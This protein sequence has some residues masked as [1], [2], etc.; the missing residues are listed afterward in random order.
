MIRSIKINLRCCRSER[1]LSSTSVTLRVTCVTSASNKATTSSFERAHNTLWPKVPTNLVTRTIS[2]WRHRSTEPD[3]FSRD[4]MITSRDSLLWELTKRRSQGKL[5]TL[6]DH[7]AP[8]ELPSTKVPWWATTKATRRT[9]WLRKKLSTRCMVGIGD[10]LDRWWQI[11]TM[12]WLCVSSLILSLH[13]QLD[14]CRIIC[15]RTLTTLKLS[16]PQLRL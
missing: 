7:L 3:L 5:K 13:L 15:S 12:Q 1:K 11:Q 4:Q 9:I 16:L 14:K 2:L 8:S 10:Q 6:I